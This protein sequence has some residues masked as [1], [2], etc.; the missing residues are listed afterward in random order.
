MYIW[1]Q[2]TTQIPYQGMPIGRRIGLE[3]DDVAAI[4][5]TCRAWASIHGQNSVGVWGGSPPYTV[6]KSKN[7]TFSVQGGYPGMENVDAMEIV[8][9]RVSTS[10]MTSRSARSW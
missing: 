1:S 6:H 2:G 7:G 3:P 5:R 9:G 8:E 4:A 10:S